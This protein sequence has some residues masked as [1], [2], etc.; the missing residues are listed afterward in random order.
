M[1]MI[2]LNDLEQL[3]GRRPSGV[4]CSFLSAAPRRRDGPQECE[5]I[6]R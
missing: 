5:A 6:T 4:N 1:V 2:Q 3:S